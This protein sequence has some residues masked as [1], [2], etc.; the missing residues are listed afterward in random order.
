MPSEVRAIYATANTVSSAKRVEELIAFIHA[1]DMNALVV[2]V[3]DGDG[4]YLGKGMQALVERLKK[5]N[6]YGI[7]RVVVFQDNYFAKQ[8]PEHAL[9]TASG[10]LWRGGGYAWMDPA[11]KKV[12]EYNAAVALKALDIGFSEVNLDYVRFPADGKLDDIVYPV[13]DG[14]TYKR[15][16]IADF[17]AYMKQRVKEKYPDRALSADV[18]AYSFL[19]GDDVGIGQRFTD[20]IASYDA[21]APMIYPS[22]FSPGN[23]EY[24]NPADAPYDVVLA[25]LQNGLYLMDTAGTSTIIRPWLQDFNMGAVYDREKIQ[26]ELQAVRDAGLT[27]GYMMWNPSNRY[28]I[29][30]Y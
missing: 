23:F 12:W 26:A 4:V 6:I 25:T 27:T 28:D 11:V 3:K 14:V 9:K 15:K 19:T 24:E 7:A 17:S 5:E 18:F 13:Y 20:L 21:I 22:H 1:A 29:R 16:I 30:K 8:H 2:N 10:T